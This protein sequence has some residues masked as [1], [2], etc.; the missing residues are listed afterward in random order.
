MHASVP[1]IR[2]YP[3]RRNRLAFFLALHPLHTTMCSFKHTCTTPLNWACSRFREELAPQHQLHLLVGQPLEVVEGDLHTVTID[4]LHPQHR[5]NH[6]QYNGTH[7]HELG[8]WI[9]YGHRTVDPAIALRNRFR[10][11][12]SSPHASVN[13]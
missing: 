1:E 8:T 13:G 2:T 10:R 12:V 5:T 11:D 9:T 7:I 6:Q 4:R 3:G